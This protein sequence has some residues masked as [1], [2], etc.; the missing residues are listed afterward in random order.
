VTAARDLSRAPSWLAAALLVVVA[1]LTLALRIV[2]LSVALVADGTDRAAGLAAA[3]DEALTARWG[4]AP[5]GSALAVVVDP[6]G[7]ETPR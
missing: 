3:V 1:V 6:T 4:L 7:R 2:A 5:L